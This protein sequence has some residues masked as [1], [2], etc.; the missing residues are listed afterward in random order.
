MI[1]PSFFATLPSAAPSVACHQD[2]ND[3]API[4]PDFENRGA[5]QRVDSE[6]AIALSDRVWRDLAGLG[7]EALVIG[8]AF[9][10]ILALAVF[11]VARDAPAGH[12]ASA[13]VSVTT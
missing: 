9:S 4:R 3:D 6:K 7:V 13:V 10:L 2:C 8:L 11:V 12:F 1:P 5:M